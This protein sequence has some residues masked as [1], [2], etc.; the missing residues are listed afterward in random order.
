MI[1]A[2]SGI[3]SWNMVSQRSH[4]HLCGVRINST[5][6]IAPHDGH[7][8]CT[9]SMWCGFMAREA[10]P[11]QAADQLNARERVLTARPF[12]LSSVCRL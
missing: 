11:V 7:V 6:H 5:S 4:S 3:V 12:A 1:G 8:I 9:V 2:P 10:L